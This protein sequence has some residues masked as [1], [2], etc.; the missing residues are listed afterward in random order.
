MTETQFKSTTRESSAGN[1]K[2]LIVRGGN[3]LEKNSAGEMVKSPLPTGEDAALIGTFEGSVANKYDPTKTDRSI[4]LLDGT[5]VILNE[6][7]NI[8]RGFASV[9]EGELV[10]IVYNGKRQMTRGANAGKSVHDFD[11]QRAINADDV[12]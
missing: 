3:I 1:G 10:R 9:A 7:A 12:G 6:T 4:R 11:I 2:L 5:L 8:K